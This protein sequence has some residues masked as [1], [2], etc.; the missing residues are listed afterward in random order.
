MVKLLLEEKAEGVEVGD[1][2]GAV[3]SYVV[4][5]KQAGAEVVKL[6]L[7]VHA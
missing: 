1:W 3:W 4:V 2:S 7:E 6:L 5:A